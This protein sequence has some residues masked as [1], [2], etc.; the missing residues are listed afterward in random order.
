MDDLFIDY[1]ISKMSLKEKIGQLLYIDYRKTNEKIIGMTNDFEK[2]LNEYK[3]GGF[4]LFN[5]NISDFN[6]TKKF[7]K[8]IQSI[9]GNN[10]FIGIDQEGG[11]VQRLGSNVGFKK[12]PA[13]SLINDKEEAYLLGK[14]VGMELF[15]IGVN[16]NMAPVMDI[17]SNPENIVMMNRTYGSDPYEVSEK[18]LSFAKGL[19][20]VK[21]IPVVKHFPGHGS[22]NVNSHIDLPM[23][24]KTKEELYNLELIPFIAAIKEKIS[25]IMVG[26]ILLSK[27]DKYPASTS[28]VIVDKLLRKELGYNGI[29]M[30]DSLKMKA[31]TKYYNDYEISYRC[32]KAGNDCILMPNDIRIS[33]NAIYNA[34]NDGKISINRINTSLRRILS[35]KLEMGLLDK[36]YLLYI[37]QRNA[38]K[39]HL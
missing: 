19:K 13:A 21:I 16:M 33:F 17:W 30:T 14:E 37:K 20:E 32:I 7:I 26:H 8:D 10:M 11:S 9:N 5:S 4:I 25:C 1:L 39:K 3:P 38:L 18:A 15:S 35:L 2:I 22:T 34:V 29:V 27:L 6:N 28:E 31:L 36:E 23:L 12:I 24:Y